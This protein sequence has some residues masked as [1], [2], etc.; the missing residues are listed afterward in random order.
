MDC[1]DGLFNLITNIDE[2]RKI[3]EALE[4][5]NCKQFIVNPHECS[6]KDCSKIYCKQCWSLNRRCRE[7]GRTEANKDNK[8]HLLYRNNMNKVK[9]LCPNLGCEERNLT[10]DT[11]EK[12]ILSQC[13]YRQIKC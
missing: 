2:V 10:Y 13:H 3:M 9:F 4:C 1:K 12:H 8:V 7:C 11:L 6:N 5:T